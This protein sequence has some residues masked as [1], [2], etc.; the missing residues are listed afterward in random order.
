MQPHDIDRKVNIKS[1]S[2]L[3]KF[4][5][6]TTVAFVLYN[7]IHVRHPIAPRLVPSTLVPLSML[8]AHEYCHVLQYRKYPITFLF[9]YFGGIVWGAVSGMWARARSTTP[10]RN[11]LFEFLKQWVKYKEYFHRAY[12]LHP[13]E[14]EARIYEIKNY[15]PWQK[16]LTS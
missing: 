2:W 16:F 13:F 15:T 3:W 14:I 5:P 7:T 10:R 6:R 12:L 11:T 8:L 1:G 9:I 4:M